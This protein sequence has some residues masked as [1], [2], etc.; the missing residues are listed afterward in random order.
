MTDKKWLFSREL[1]VQYGE[2]MELVGRI[3]KWLHSSA[4]LGEVMYLDVLG[5]PTIIFNSL[6][7]AF[8][9]LERRARNSPGRP[10]YIIASEVLNQ[11]L[12]L[13]RM[14]YSDL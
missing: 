11:G 5:K 13:V 1:K 14:D 10:R 7:S 3:L 8:D 12:G 9:V 4:R 6:K 2:Y